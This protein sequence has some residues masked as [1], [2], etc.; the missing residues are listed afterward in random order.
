MYVKVNE[1]NGFMM[2]Q[3]L[4]TEYG[5]VDPPVTRGADDPAPE[6]TMAPVPTLIVH[7][8]GESL[9]I[10]GDDAIRVMRNCFSIPSSLVTVLSGAMP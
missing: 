2:E 1:T 7:F 5:L 9:T 4:Y 8:S 3:V 6:A 10:T